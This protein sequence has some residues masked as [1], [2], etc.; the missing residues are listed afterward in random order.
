MKIK[1]LVYVFD[2][3]I[4]DVEFFFIGFKYFWCVYGFLG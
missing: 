3:M 2:M 1:I 4:V